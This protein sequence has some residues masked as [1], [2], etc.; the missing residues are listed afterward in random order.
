[1]SKN[2]TVNTTSSSSTIPGA[3]ITHI[4]KHRLILASASPR[5]QEMMTSHGYSPLLFPADVDETIPSFLA[6]E[7]VVMHLS[8]T[9][10]F[11]VKEAWNGGANSTDTESTPAIIVS[12]D[13]VVVYNGEIL[14]KPLDRNDAFRMLSMMAGHQ[15]QVMTGVS[16]TLSDK[17]FTK[18]FYEVTTVTFDAFSEEDINAYLDTDEP[19]DKAGSYAIQGAFRKH[20]SR[21]DGDINNVIGFPWARFVKELEL[22]KLD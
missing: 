19:Y 17:L 2:P 22:L 13:T 5:R 12:A 9:K 21:T 11:A 3:S 4:G 6:P 20:I 10:G 15:H 8:R 7:E 1:M 18:C 14:G 16:L